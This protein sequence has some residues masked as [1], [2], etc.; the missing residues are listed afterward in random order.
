MEATR[1]AGFSVNEADRFF[2][3]PDE[4]LIAGLDI[5]LRPP[6]ETRH[7]FTRR[8]SELLGECT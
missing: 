6:L 4:Q 3:A 8:H 7:A 5:V 2:G 1:I